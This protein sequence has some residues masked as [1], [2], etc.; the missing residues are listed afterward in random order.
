MDGT[1]AGSLERAKNVFPLGFVFILIYCASLEKVFQFLEAFSSGLRNGLCSRRLGCSCGTPFDADVVGVIALLLLNNWEKL[2]AAA[3]SGQVA[4]ALLCT[5]RLDSGRIGGR[6]CC[7]PSGKYSQHGAK[8]SHTHL[9]WVL[10][11]IV[12]FRVSACVRSYIMTPG[13]VVARE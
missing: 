13:R 12:F 4:R 8:K 6:R 2:E 5:S 11:F 3:A 9:H 1:C 10:R 7:T